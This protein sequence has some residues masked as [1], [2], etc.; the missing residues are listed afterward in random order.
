MTERI[1]DIY[2]FSGISCLNKVDFDV[3]VV[4]LFRPE[5]DCNEEGRLF[6]SEFI[7]ELNNGW[8]K[9][10]E[11]NRLSDKEIK[12]LYLVNFNILYK[13]INGK[14]TPDT[15]IYSYYKYNPIFSYPLVR[16]LEVITKMEV[17]LMNT[18]TTIFNIDHSL[19][20]FASWNSEFSREFFLMN[21][22]YFHG[23]ENR[24]KLNLVESIASL[25]YEGPMYTSIENLSYVIRFL[26]EGNVFK[27][28]EYYLK[29]FINIPGFKEGY[30]KGEIKINLRKS[31]KNAIFNFVFLVRDLDG[32]KKLLKDLKIN[33]G[34][35]KNRGQINF[36]MANLTRIDTGFRKS[37]YLYNNT[38]GA[39][40]EKR[41]FSF[42]NIHMN[43]GNVRYF[44]TNTR[45]PSYSCM[46]SELI[47]GEGGNK[48]GCRSFSAK[49]GGEGMVRVNEVV[50][51]VI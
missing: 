32:L 50:S 2:N 22:E 19:I 38:I 30:E 11:E 6:N 46:L 14:T 10:I 21:F 23:K 42:K 3:Q 26:F 13:N 39:G 8:C 47:T 17:Q 27:V 16:Y 48:L 49:Q 51:V 7:N 25:S 43:L 44:S 40:L 31:N 12:W 41:D 4:N 28:W 9:N 45:N 36:S 29:Y 34:P 5:V 37:M 35:Q 1:K 15:L 33:C 20:N 24:N 18:E